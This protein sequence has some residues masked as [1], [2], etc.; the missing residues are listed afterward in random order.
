VGDLTI[1][2]LATRSHAIREY[3]TEKRLN[4]QKCLGYYLEA[5]PRPTAGLLMALQ[6]LPD[7]LRDIAVVRSMYEQRIFTLGI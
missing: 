7:W 4:C 5:N 3:E 2:L 6:S 1:H